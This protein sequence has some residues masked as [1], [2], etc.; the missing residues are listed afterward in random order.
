MGL[1]V[2]LM[3]RF[4]PSEYSWTP[5]IDFLCTASVR[6]CVYARVFIHTPS[7]SSLP[8]LFLYPLPSISLLPPFLFCHFPPSAGLLLLVIKCS[9]IPDSLGSCLGRAFLSFSLAGGGTSWR[10]QNRK[11]IQR[12]VLRPVIAALLLRCP[13]QRKSCWERWELWGER[14]RNFQVRPNSTY[15]RQAPGWGIKR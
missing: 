12:S 13:Q 3:L 14:S 2:S 7:K 5:C 10:K 8:P 1:G 9:S 15:E 4:C 11:T 6:V